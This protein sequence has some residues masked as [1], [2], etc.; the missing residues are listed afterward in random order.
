MDYYTALLKSGKILDAYFEQSKDI[1]HNGN[2][3]TVRENIKSLKRLKR[4]GTHSWTVTPLVSIQVN[5]LP[6][7]TDRN[8]YFGI[9]FAYDSLEPSTILEHM[10]TIN[11]PTSLL[12]N[13]IV[14][15]RR[16]AI[17]I[18][19]K[20]QFIEGFPYNDFDKYVLLDCGDETFAIFIGLLINFTR[21]S[22]LSVADVPEQINKALERIFQDNLKRGTI[23]ELHTLRDALF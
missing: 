17:I 23:K 5:G 18:Q 7:N 19:A 12:P 21:Y 15:Y 3:G 22:L 2:K 11:I 1:L 4:Q 14:L 16:N 20:N 9:I 6:N 13:V 8:P 10:K